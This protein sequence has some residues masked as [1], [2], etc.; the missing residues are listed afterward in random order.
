[1]MVDPKTMSI[2]EKILEV[3]KSV[4]YLKKE[5][6]GY[7]YKY[8][9]GSQVLGALREKLD[10]LGL[11]LRPE[12]IGATYQ[13]TKT[14]KAEKTETKTPKE[15]K[16]ENLV[17]IEMLFTWYNVHKPEEKIECR[18]VSMG[19]NEREKGIGSAITYAERYFLLKF[20]MIATDELDPD[21]YKEKYTQGEESEMDTYT[22]QARPLISNLSVNDKIPNAIMPPELHGRGITFLELGKNASAFTFATKT[23]GPQNGRYLL[24]YWAKA[25]GH[26]AYTLANQV[27]DVLSQATSPAEGPTP[28]Q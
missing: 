16:T 23:A 25:P 1:M 5:T 13:E 21:A 24:N 2:Y 4:P 15:E 9:K 12:I 10:E 27:L 8:V 7:N 6:K 3:R 19:Q 22:P 17:K 11:L 26:P 18:W 14:P 28:Q 20:F